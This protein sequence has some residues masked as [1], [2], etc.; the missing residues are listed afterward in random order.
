MTESKTKNS[1]SK[2]V[3]HH[4]IYFHHQKK[5]CYFRLPFQSLII[6]FSSLVQ[7]KSL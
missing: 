4:K 1:D 6:S 7:V 2:G 3:E 5:K